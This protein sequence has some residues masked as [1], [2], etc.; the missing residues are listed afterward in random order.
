MKEI[1]RIG[2][3]ALQGDFR[4]HA[5]MLEEIGARTREVRKSA[6]L[7]G[8]DGLVIPG[9]ESSTLLKLMEDTDFEALSSLYSL[10][11]EA[12]EGRSRSR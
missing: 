5:R 2:V 10:H 4:A 8:L 12:E 7:A 9:G 6:D 1:P 11:M 3:L